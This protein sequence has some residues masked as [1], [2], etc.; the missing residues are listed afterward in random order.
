MT[1]SDANERP[2]WPRFRRWSEMED[3]TRYLLLGMGVFALLVWGFLQT[4]QVLETGRLWPAVRETLLLLAV[5]GVFLF[6]IGFY[7]IRR[8]EATLLSVAV[9]V[10][11][12]TAIWW[13]IPSE[14]DFVQQA[15]ESFAELAAGG[16]V[17]VLALYGRV[18]AALAS[19]VGVAGL[20]IGLRWAVPPEPG[21]LQTGVDA[22][23]EGLWWGTVG[24]LLL[25]GVERAG[26]ITFPWDED[27]A[28][29]GEATAG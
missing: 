17:M 4:V 26:L 9:L 22:G 15:T 8:I 29:T 14:R 12:L 6:V 24:G 19:A 27:E 13:G 16:L 1:T 18:A 21:L 5:F 3:W 23:M 7:K 10:A 25:Y 11:L 28:D 20:L 2:D